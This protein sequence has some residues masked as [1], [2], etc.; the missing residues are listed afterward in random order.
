MDEHSAMMGVDTIVDDRCVSV[1]QQ[2]NLLFAKGNAK[3]SQKQIEPSFRRCPFL[4]LCNLEFDFLTM[5]H[6]QPEIRTKLLTVDCANMIKSHTPGTGTQIQVAQGDEPA[7]LRAFARDVEQRNIDVRGVT[8]QDSARIVTRLLVNHH[9][10]EQASANGQRPTGKQVVPFEPD[11][12]A[13]AN[14]L[15]SVKRAQTTYMTMGG[16]ETLTQFADS[17]DLLQTE[18][19]LESFQATHR[20]L[21]SVHEFA[22][23]RNKQTRTHA[24]TATVAYIAQLRDALCRQLGPPL[25]LQQQLDSQSHTIN[26]RTMTVRNQNTTIVGLKQQ[27]R[28]LQRRPFP[29]ES[30]DNDSED[31]DD[32]NNDDDN[33]DSNKRAKTAVSPD[34]K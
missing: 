34:D 25:A 11:A 19:G 14:D 7:A 23:H 29:S 21:S 5:A 24:R 18:M 10:N 22:T 2:N 4:L 20:V 17:T 15:K 8:S 30:H 31:G 27:I 1:L 3:C 28:L 6:N 12:Y 33:N 13:L 26:Q 32:D 9:F 16:V